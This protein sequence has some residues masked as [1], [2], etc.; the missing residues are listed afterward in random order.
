M[1]DK[2]YGRPKNDEKLRLSIMDNEQPFQ[3]SPT[4]YIG[5]KFIGTWSRLINLQNSLFVE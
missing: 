1:S 3:Y 5:N 4:D 2:A